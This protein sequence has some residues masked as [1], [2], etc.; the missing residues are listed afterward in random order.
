VSLDSF[1]GELGHGRAPSLSL[2]TESSIEIVGKLDSGSLHVCQH[3]RG[4]EPLADGLHPVAAVVSGWPGASGA[5]SVPRT[6][7]WQPVE[8]RPSTTAAARHLPVRWRRSPR[9]R[10]ATLGPLRSS[11]PHRPLS[12]VAAFA[13]P[14]RYRRSTPPGTRRCS[15]AQPIR[16]SA[17]RPIV[18]PGGIQPGRADGVV[19]DEVFERPGGPDVVAGEGRVGRR[20][21]VSGAGD[22]GGVHPGPTSYSRP[23]RDRELRPLAGL[24]THGSQP[25]STT[26]W[27]NPSDAIRTLLTGTPFSLLVSAPSNQ[28][29]QGGS[30]VAT[31]PGTQLPAPP[32]PAGRP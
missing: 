17:P 31:P 18:A 29:R 2:V 24:A 3:T 1:S 10:P 12:S 4:V 32:A 20:R 30:G 5:D 13:P 11:I 8:D 25:Q 22:P 26:A 23:N 27:P 7:Q 19:D 16:R 6:G 21:A 28:K 15:V 14:V 9:H